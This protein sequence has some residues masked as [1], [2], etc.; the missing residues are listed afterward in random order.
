MAK[1]CNHTLHPTTR[2][3]TP[4][5]S[6]CTR[7]VLDVELGTRMKI[8]CSNCDKFYGYIVTNA[9]EVKAIRGRPSTKK[10][11]TTARI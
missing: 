2:D 7:N 3:G 6:W 8:E 10:H 9:A 5:G 11:A 1:E 4:Q